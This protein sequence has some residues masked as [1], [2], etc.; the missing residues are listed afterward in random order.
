MC[1]SDK[2]LRANS[3]KC[4][5]LIN[6]DENVALKIEMITNENFLV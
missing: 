5:L 2:F 1:F 4:H 6:T 3:D